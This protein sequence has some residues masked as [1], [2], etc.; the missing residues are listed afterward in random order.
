MK[1]GIIGAGAAGVFAAIQVK[2]NFPKANVEILEKSNKCLAKVKISGGG[3]CNVTTGISEIKILANSY[4]RGKNQMKKILHQFNSTDTQKWFKQ[5]GVPL[6]TEKDLRVFPKSND[7]QSIID[8]LLG[9]LKKHQTSIIYQYPIDEIELKKSRFI[10]KSKRNGNSRTYEYLIIATGGSPKKSGYLWLEKI[11]LKIVP[12]VPSLFTFN[13]PKSNIKKLMGISMPKAIVKIIGSKLNSQ[14]PLLITHWGFSGPA[15]LKLSAFA[16][17]EL[18]E[19]QYDFKILINWIGLTDQGEVKNHILSKQKTDGKK[20]IGHI[21]LFEIPSRLWTYLISKSGLSDDSLFGE[22]GLKSIN[23]IINTLCN[24]EY[25]VHGKTTFKEEFVTAG[26]IDLSTVH[27]NSLES[28]VH[29]K[30]FFCG[31]VLNFDGITGGFNF[32]VAWSTAYIAGKL[33]M[34]K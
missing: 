23:K 34:T 10:L 7:S 1:V 8:C 5:R 29:P 15:V 30:L 19:K 11:G 32:Q 26:G 21:K 13:V 24:D 17:R 6:K 16:A 4:P 2:S 3:R 22:L 33:N 31:E 18:N 20:R 14:G 28:K 9:E 12:P 27:I 25:H